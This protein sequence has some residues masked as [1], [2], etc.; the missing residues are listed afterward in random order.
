MLKGFKNFAMRGSVVD[1]AVGVI[2]GAA[3]PEDC[4]VAGGGRDH[5]AAGAIA[6][7][8]EFFGVVY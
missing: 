1:L 8:C 4:V 3:F 6:Q 7:S 5:A 2:I